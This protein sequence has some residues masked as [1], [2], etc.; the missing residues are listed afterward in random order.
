MALGA[1]TQLLVSINKKPVIHKPVNGFL[2]FILLV[3]FKP[4]PVLLKNN[5]PR[6]PC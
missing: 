3:I 5:Q 6:V 1:V 4:K 2:F